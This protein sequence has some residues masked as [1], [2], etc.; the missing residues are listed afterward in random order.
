[1]HI[2]DNFKK[3]LSGF[4]DGDGSIT[5]EKLSNGYTLRIKF[6]QSNE[7]ILKKIQ[8][9]Y[10]FMRLDGGQRNYLY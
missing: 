8:Q 7:N 5:V 10:P 3:Y 9:H 1:M 4:F 2:T 6:C